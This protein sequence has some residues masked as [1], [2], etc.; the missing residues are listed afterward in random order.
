MSKL[1]IKSPSL[2][3][4]PFI[5]TNTFSPT[6]AT[7]SIFKLST[8]VNSSSWKVISDTVSFGKSSIIGSWITALGFTL[9]GCA[10]L[11]NGLRDQ[12]SKFKISSETSVSSDS[13]S[14]L[15]LSNSF[16]FAV[17]ARALFFALPLPAFAVLGPSLPLG[18]FLLTTCFVFELP[19]L[20]LSYQS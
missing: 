9:T 5:I 16:C 12:P 20:F 19:I 2:N 17:F 1:L 15:L 8:P 14:C 18:F 4:C 6:L 13:A 3:L 7:V 11:I 10:T